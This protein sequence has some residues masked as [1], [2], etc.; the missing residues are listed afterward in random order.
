M[1]DKLK[2]HPP[3]INFSATSEVHNSE[4]KLLINC[5]LRCH[6]DDAQNVNEFSDILVSSLNLAGSW[7][8][9]NTADETQG[10]RAVVTLFS[11]TAPQHTGTGLHRNKPCRQNSELVLD[12]IQFR[13]V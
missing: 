4:L 6:H 8:L 7:F 9:R 10:V 3:L 13:S 5:F 1:E 12:N 11:G 2:L